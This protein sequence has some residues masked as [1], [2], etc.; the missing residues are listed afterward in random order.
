MD[1]T[2]ADLNIE[3]YQRLLASELDATKRETIGRLLT[4][5]KAKLA[6]NNEE[7]RT[8]STG[9]SSKST[10]PNAGRWATLNKAEEVCGLALSSLILTEHIVP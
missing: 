8:F 1:K 3:H 9:S 6:D 5:G 7:T 4:K 10:P 2:I